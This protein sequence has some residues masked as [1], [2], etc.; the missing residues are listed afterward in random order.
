[1]ASN[2]G[3]IARVAGNLL[4]SNPVL[5][6]GYGVRLLSSSVV[7]QDHARDTRLVVTRAVEVARLIVAEVARTEPSE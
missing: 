3:T 2:A 6:N 7:S 4:S 5:G 1:M